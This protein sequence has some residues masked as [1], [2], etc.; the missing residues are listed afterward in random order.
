MS[1]VAGL[2]DPIARGSG[3]GLLRRAWRERRTRATLHAAARRWRL[4][5]SSPVGVLG[6]RTIELGEAVVARRRPR[7]LALDGER[8]IERRHGERTSVRLVAGPTPIDV[9]A[10]MRRAPRC[11]ARN[12]LA[13]A[14][15]PPS[16]RRRVMSVAAPPG[17]GELTQE[18]LLEAYRVMRTI[19]EFEE[20]AAR[21]VRD[22]RDP[23]LRAPVRGRGGDRRRRLRAPRRPTTTSPARI[24]ATATHR[25]GL[26]RQGHDGRDLRQDDGLCHG[27][28]GSM[29]I[30]D[31]AEGMLGANGIV[32]GGPP[33]GLRCRADGEDA[34]GT[35]QRGR[36][37]HRRR[38]LQPGHDPRE[39]EPRV[40]VEPAVRLRGREQRLRRVDVAELPPE[41][42]RHRQARR[43]LRHARRRRRR[44]RLLRRA[45]GRRRGDRACARAAAGRR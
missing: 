12:A 22:R 11:N 7:R 23:G 18:Q 5:S 2:L 14:R 16:S 38:R 9:D 45:R 24:A 29:H 43:R 34:Q 30:A 13:S 39:P 21:R 15:L 36:L 33:L 41:R 42:R 17:A 1:S 32:G 37:V 28:G 26:R 31:L 19:R 10:V 8:E 35:E 3:R 6:F 20:R 40:G 27:K 4:A 25:Q 44:L